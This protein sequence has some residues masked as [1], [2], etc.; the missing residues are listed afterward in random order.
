MGRVSVNGE[1]TVK[2]RFHQPPVAMRPYFTTFYITEI[3]AGE[4]GQVTD[5]LHPEWANLRIISGA[6]PASEIRQE[7]PVTGMAAIVT[8]PT[9]TTVRFTT[10]T[11]RIW[12]IGLLPLGWAKFVS[13]P[14]HAFADRLCD[15]AQE[16]AFAPLLPL[17]DSLFGPTPDEPAELARITEHFESLAARKV[18][19]EARI[20]A[21]HRALVD[22]EIASVAAMAEH[23]GLPS[24]TLERICRRH[25]GFPPILLLR[26][27]RFMRSLSQYMLDPSLTWIGAI[28]SHYHDQ[29]Q[30]VREFHRFMGM[31]PRAYAALPHPVLAGV[32]RARMLAAGAPVQ[33]LHV[34]PTA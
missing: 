20:L 34:P 4:T 5:H 16:P 32:M 15:P 8:G 6:L 30:F 31:G 25:F 21:T 10:G 14:A 24:H 27:Q 11:S 1:C 13:A 9:S 33:A 18:P 22:P 2:V 12:G 28:D 26:R 19:D 29:A 17:A 3:E 23:A 7:P